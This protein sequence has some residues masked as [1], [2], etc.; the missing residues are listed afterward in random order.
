MYAIVWGSELTTFSLFKLL[1]FFV[2]SL[3]YMFVLFGHRDPLSF[4][5][6]TILIALPVLGIIMPPVR[7]QISLFDFLSLVIFLMLVAKKMQTGRRIELFP[8]RY[9]WL[10]I[11]LFIP[12]VVTAIAP[13]NSV[14][15]MARFLGTYA[16]FVIGYYYLQQPGW[17]DRFHRLL[18]LSLLVVSFFVVLQKVTGINLMIYQERG[19]VAAG[20]FMIKQ[21][22]GLF[23]DPQKA[24]QFIAVF[25]SYFTILW[26]RKSLTGKWLN[27]IALLAIIMSIPALLLTVSRLAMASGF[28]VAFFGFFF[29][30]KS[31]LYGRLI[32][33]SLLVVL[34]VAFLGFGSQIIEKAMPREVVK[35]FELT[36]SSAEGRYIVWQDSWIIFTEY[37]ITGIGIGNYQE[38]W[39]RKNPALRRYE[40][41]GDLIPNQPESGYLKV[42]YE[43][44]LVGLLAGLYF[45]MGIVRN[46]VRTLRSG[47][48]EE[49]KS[50]A[51]A[52]LGGMIAFLVTYTTLF[53]S[54]DPRNALIPLL[55]IMALLAA[56]RSV[57]MKKVGG[58]G[59][60]AMPDELQGVQGRSRGMVG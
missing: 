34:V 28:G 14:I 40:N 19:V 27:N 43:G 2:P 53:T 1:V 48:T 15:E 57:P 47:K 8:V 29:L 9:V 55:L 36:K 5:F 59:A 3:I 46:S 30:N 31:N 32:V 25:M 18:A 12:S 45:V 24:G 44:G 58:L 52:V 10:P 17:L 51:W 26:S 16:V 49:T 39:L 50:I 7:F 22:S 38:Y 13:F 4:E 33:S 54:S 41:V 11:L 20:D 56:P 23:Q 60:E 42:L 37:P 35:R 21:G 6:S